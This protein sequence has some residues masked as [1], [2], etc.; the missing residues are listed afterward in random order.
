MFG[1]YHQ[2]RLQKKVTTLTWRCSTKLI[3]NF[4]NFVFFLLDLFIIFFI[5]KRKI[6][7]YFSIKVTF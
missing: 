5:N 7:N 4:T 6:N 3:V 1:G 2:N